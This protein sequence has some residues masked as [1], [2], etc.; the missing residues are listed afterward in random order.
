M[1]VSFV[2]LLK[3]KRIKT[4]DAEEDMIPG[5]GPVSSGGNG[6]DIGPNDSHHRL[7]SNHY[8]SQ[9][10]GQWGKYIRGFNSLV[11]DDYQQ[12]TRRLFSVISGFSWK[13]FDKIRLIFGHSYCTCFCR[14]R[15]NDIN[16]L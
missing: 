2:F 7:H 4:E 15:C 3:S 10:N 13:D 11:G 8:Q 1:T 12:A 16:F 9:H 14:K 5:G 6:T